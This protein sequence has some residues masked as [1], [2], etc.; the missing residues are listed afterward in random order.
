VYALDLPLYDSMGAMS[1]ATGIPMAALKHAKNNGCT[2]IRHGRSD[3]GEFLRWFFARTGED[4]NESSIN[5]ADRDKRASALIK[6]VI[7]EQKRE[8]LIEFK[9]VETFLN[10]LVSVGFFGELDRLANEFPSSLKGRTEISINEEC[11]KQTN[12]IKIALKSQLE[13]WIKAKGKN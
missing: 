12:N 2:F 4:E 3:L 11:M 10:N 6:E 13:N 8:Q 9:T 1:G 7:L 5:W